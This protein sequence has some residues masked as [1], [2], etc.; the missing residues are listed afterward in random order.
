MKSRT[1]TTIQRNY[2]RE[3]VKVEPTALYVQLAV[4]VIGSWTSYELSTTLQVG[5]RNLIIHIFDSMESTYGGV[6]TR[7]ALGLITYAVDGLSDKELMDLLTIHARVMS[8]EGVNEFNE[9]SRLPSH[10]WLRLRS[11]VFGLVMERE[12]GRLVWFHRQLK[13]AAEERYK[14]EKQY[15]HEIMAKYF[16]G[17][18]SQQDQEEKGLSIQTLTLNCPIEEIWSPKA[19]INRRRCVESCHHLLAA[20]CYSE[21]EQ[22]LCTIEAVYVAA[23]CGL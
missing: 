4:R 20:G 14:D 17:L 21:A 5:V 18:I 3:Q 16:S 2:V 19:L 9:A 15:L 11:E 13:E 12:G 10:V 1:L 23:K 6:F 22:E 8:K 7:A